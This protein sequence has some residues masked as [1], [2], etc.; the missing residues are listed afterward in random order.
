MRLRPDI[1]LLDVHMPGSG[2]RAAAA[3]YESVPA[4]TIVM[5]TVSRS[6]GDL[7]AALKAGAAGYLVKDADPSRL[8][9][10]LGAVLDGEAAL[11]RTLVARLIEEF[12]RRDLRDARLRELEEDGVVLTRREWEVL[13]LLADGRTTAEIAATLDIA[14]VTVRT[15]V[16]TVVKKL[17]VESREEA[18]RR[19]NGDR[20]EQTQR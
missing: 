9:H 2:I 16:A 10:A 6:D 11:P 3:I 19:V 8:A 5:L 17:Q 20:V 13:E 12:R 1:C 7:F 14:Q 15:H 4:T 18:V